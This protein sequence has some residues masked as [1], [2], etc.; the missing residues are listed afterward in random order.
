MASAQ[1]GKGSQ[2]FLCSLYDLFSVS[3]A[4]DLRQHVF[5]ARSILTLH[6]RLTNMICLCSQTYATVMTPAKVVCVLASV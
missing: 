6:L 4:T 1:D 3:F 5:E 2:P